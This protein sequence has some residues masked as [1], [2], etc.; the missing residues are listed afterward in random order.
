MN[1]DL[2]RRALERAKRAD[3]PQ[4]SPPL[5]PSQST[6]STS[7]QISQRTRKQSDAGS[8]FSFSSQQ[9][10]FT[11]SLK[12]KGSTMFSK[13]SS[14]K[15]PESMFRTTT[16]QSGIYSNP[17]FANSS[18]FKS[19]LSLS[20][21]MHSFQSYSFIRPVKCGLCNE[22]MWG[23]SEY[24]CDHCGILA[25]SRCLNKMTQDNLSN[26]SG[27]ELPSASFMHPS[28]SSSSSIKSHDAK[29]KKSVSGMIFI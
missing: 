7:L 18:A 11:R 4:N 9:S 22:K 16:Q 8:V 6:E 25:H 21:C 19:S 20:E 3:I 14:N 15:K 13:F 1:N 26:D 12:K 2:S 28:V 17:N 10:T 29:P 24:R 27:L 5:S 23:R